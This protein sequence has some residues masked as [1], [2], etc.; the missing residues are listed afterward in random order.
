MVSFSR[1]VEQ[2]T[3]ESLLE[4]DWALNLQITD[5]VCITVCTQPLPH[6]VRVDWS[7]QHDLIV[8]RQW[9]L[10]LASLRMASPSAKLAETAN[11]CTLRLT[12]GHNHH[13][14][15]HHLSHLSQVRSGEIPGKEAIRQVKKRMFNRNAN[16][17]LYTLTLLEALVKNCG[18]PV[19][20]TLSQCMDTIHA[21]HVMS[22]LSFRIG[23]PS[24]NLR[25]LHLT[26]DPNAFVLCSQSEVATKDFMDQFR[27][28]IRGSIS[29]VKPR[30]LELIQTWAHAFENQPRYRCVCVHACVCVLVCVCVCEMHQQVIFHTLDQRLR[31]V[32]VRCL[33][34]FS[35]VCVQR[36]I[37][38]ETY[39]VLRM[40]GHEFPTYNP[41]SDAMFVAEVRGPH[42]HHLAIFMS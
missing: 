31:L 36:R 19:Q 20:V 6:S 24:C 32:R 10:S 8:S 29:T 9:L 13:H 30:C 14:H 33:L 41:T 16:V 27:R 1:L 4:P 34:T 18:G 12:W 35:L 21:A 25:T 11:S 22:S 3:A 28:L 15:C 42:A 26:R 38:T 5:L 37:V 2:A 40:E 39:N 23:A 7:L 17:V